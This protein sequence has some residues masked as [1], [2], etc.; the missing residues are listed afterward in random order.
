MTDA[1]D[2]IKALKSKRNT[3]REKLEK[4]K[5]ERHG[6]LGGENDEQSETGDAEAAT[7]IG[8][9]DNGKLEDLHTLCKAKDLLCCFVRHFRIRSGR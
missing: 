1:W 3:L 7:L 2:D 6:I 9:A 4:R 5:K 8:Q